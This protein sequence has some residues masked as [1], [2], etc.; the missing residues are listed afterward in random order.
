MEEIRI[1]MLESKRYDWKKIIT[2]YKEAKECI[3]N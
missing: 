2:S 1:N 3:E